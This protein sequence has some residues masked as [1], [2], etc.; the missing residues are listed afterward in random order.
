[1]RVSKLIMTMETL[2]GIASG[3]INNESQA[4]IT[5]NPDGM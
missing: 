4:I 1:M 3:L 5:N 2:P